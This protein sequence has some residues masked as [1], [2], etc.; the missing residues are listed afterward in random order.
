MEYL[1]TA[2]ERLIQDRTR[3]LGSVIDERPVADGD[4]RL[5]REQTKQERL[6]DQMTYLGASLC[7]N[8][9]DRVRYASS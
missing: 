4:E 5:L 3:D 9:E 2:T 8:M 1:F 7:S 6:K